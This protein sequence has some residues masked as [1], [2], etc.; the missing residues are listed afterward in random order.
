MEIY[1][2]YN[3]YNGG[4]RFFCVCVTDGLL[5]LLSVSQIQLCVCVTD[6]VRLCGEFILSCLCD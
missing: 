4:F 1:T 2:C 3:F 5:V 6:V